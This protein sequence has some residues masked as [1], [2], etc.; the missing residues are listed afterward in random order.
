MRILLVGINYAPDLIGVAKYNTEL[1]ESLVGEGHEVRVI[2]APP[3][4]PAWKIPA[5]FSASY[6]RAIDT[7]GVRVTRTPIYV[8]SQPTGAK[9]LVHHASFA[10]TSM[11]SVLKE[12]LTWR[13]DI[14]LSV[15]P[16][17]MSAAFASLIA[18][19]TGARSWLHIQDFEVDAAF[20]LGLLQNQKLRSA[21]LNVE[22]AILRAFDRVSSISP[23]M[24]ERLRE[25][26]VAS[27]RATE[28]R[29]WIDT[30]AIVPSSKQTKYRGQL[31]I[32]PTAVVGVYSGTMSNKQG[33]DLVIEAASL[34]E[35]SQPNLHFIL[36]GEGPH[37]AKLVEMATAH[38]RIHFLGLQPVESFNELMATADFHMIPQKAEAADLVLPSKLG[39][40]LASGRPVIAMASEGTGLAAEIDGAGLVVPPGDTRALAAAMGMLIADP[41]SCEQLGAE[42]RRRSVTRWDRQTIVR[43]W[44]DDMISMRGASGRLQ[45]DAGASATS[46][47][48]PV[49]DAVPL[50]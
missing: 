14:I 22:S 43:R 33:L 3:Y 2:T 46:A 8:P 28:V 1:C 41:E 9:R 25:K 49:K 12:A 45:A 42:G 30:T 34:L 38:P 17:L 37:K 35:S 19:R 11:L 50:P 10:L 39:A 6:F 29:N 26:G 44:L 21:M 32:S 36:A 24:V 47:P 31:G 7:N 4:Y 23:Q 5:E 13:P 20:D 48:I 27:D 18:R 16:S 40:V 15:A